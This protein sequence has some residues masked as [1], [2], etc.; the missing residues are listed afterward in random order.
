[1]QFYIEKKTNQEYPLSFGNTRV[2]SIT[3]HLCCVK[4][5]QKTDF[6]DDEPNNSKSKM[7][8]A[9]TFLFFDGRM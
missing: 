9:D 5:F 2:I 8:K 6:T 3:L 7:T 4:Y 1:M